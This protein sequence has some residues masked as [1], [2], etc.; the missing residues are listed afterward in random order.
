MG[1]ARP[2]QMAGGTDSKAAVAGAPAAPL[3]AK[4]ARGS[5]AWMEA[6]SPDDPTTQVVQ[7]VVDL[8]WQARS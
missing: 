5:A 3:S 6:H 4:P 8:M 7:C 2:A 1:G